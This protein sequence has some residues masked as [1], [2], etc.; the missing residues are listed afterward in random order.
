MKNLNEFSSELKK[1][2]QGMHDD[3]KLQDDAFSVLVRADRHRWIHQ[4]NFAGIPALQLPQDLFAIQ[5]IVF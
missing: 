4:T 5:E 1:D 2:A 3:C